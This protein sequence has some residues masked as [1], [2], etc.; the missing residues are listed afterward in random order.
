MFLN[1]I[2]TN[3]LWDTVLGY[4]SW[5]NYCASG[6][7][8]NGQQQ[9]ERYMMLAEMHDHPFLVE[10]RL[11]PRNLVIVSKHF[12][13]VK[14]KDVLE[15]VIWWKV[16]VETVSKLLPVPVNDSTFEYLVSVAIDECHDANFLSFL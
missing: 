15:A 8:A 3:L 13:S 6:R 9:L 12:G 2:E 14:R 1:F 10:C 11:K 4:D 16:V 5:A 7:F